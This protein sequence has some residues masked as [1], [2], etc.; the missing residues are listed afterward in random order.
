MCSL[1]IERKSKQTKRSVFNSFFVVA[2]VLHSEGVEIMESFGCLRMC[3]LLLFA[4]AVVSTFFCLVVF[5]RP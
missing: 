4:A 2:I 5:F 3:L 1:H